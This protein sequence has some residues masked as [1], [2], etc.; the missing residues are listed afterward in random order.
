LQISKTYQRK[1]LTVFPAYGLEFVVSNILKIV[2]DIETGL[3]NGSTNTSA[4]L[5]KENL[6]FYC[7]ITPPGH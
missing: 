1:L 4:D 2:K 6:P 5:I 3:C 7:I